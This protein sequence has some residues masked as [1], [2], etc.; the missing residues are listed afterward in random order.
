M[1]KPRPRGV[2]YLAL[3]FA[4]AVAG[5]TLA[6]TAALWSHG[7]QRQRETQLLWAG[8]Q[9]RQAIAAYARHAGDDAN[10]Y[11]R[12]LQDLLLDP[13]SA[14]PRRFL[15]RVY[16][17]PMTGRADW[18]TILDAQGRIVGVHSRSSKAP[19]KRAGFDSE[20]RGFDKARRYADWRFSAVGEPAL[21]L[22]A[23]AA[24]TAA[25]AAAH[26]APAAPTPAPAAAPTAPPAP[27]AAPEA[28]HAAPPA[29]DG[30]PTHDD[31]D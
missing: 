24:Q 11:P 5:A 6:A 12:T 1:V 7:Q 29:D 20:Q 27:L 30:A 2:T 16:D 17:D 15:R 25:P 14:A 3:L 28:V 13:R 22:A 31:A 18:V 4:V 26:A 19:L 8:E 10:R 9:I 23:H 21:H